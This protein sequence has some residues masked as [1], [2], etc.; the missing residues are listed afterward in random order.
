MTSA[1]PLAE[2]VF[3]PIRKRKNNSRRKKKSPKNSPK[4]S[5]PSNSTPP[6]KNTPQKK[7]NV[8]RE[9]FLEAVCAIMYLND[10]LEQVVNMYS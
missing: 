10:S 3:T 2:K 7:P 5:P 9:D 1:S 4:N 8:T 6:K